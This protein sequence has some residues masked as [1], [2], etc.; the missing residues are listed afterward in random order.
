MAM[1]V[2]KCANDSDATAGYRAGWEA[3]A[4]ATSWRESN[5]TRLCPHANTDDND[6]LRFQRHWRWG[7]D[8]CADHYRELIRRT[9][10]MPN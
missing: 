10:D 1:M 5:R 3:A 7:W 8:D 2:L 4:N 9:D 6:S